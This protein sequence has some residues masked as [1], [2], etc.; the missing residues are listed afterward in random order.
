MAFLRQLQTRAADAAQVD[1][2]RVVQRLAQIGFAELKDLYDE[3]GR[4]LLPHQWPAH[5]SG[6]VEQVESEE[7]F[8]RVDREDPETGKTVKRREL[9]GYVRKVKLAKEVEALKLLAQIL[10]LIGPDAEAPKKAD[11]GPVILGGVDPD[12]L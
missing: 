6:V 8:E 5:M 10:R 7:R 4:I 12:K 3:R 11:S 1:A 9:V 2:N